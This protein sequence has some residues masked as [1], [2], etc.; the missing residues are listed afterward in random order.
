MAVLDLPNW[1][2]NGMKEAVNNFLWGGKGVK[3][4]TKTLI[5]DYNKGGLKLTDL[6]V[7]R[8]AIRVKT[9]KKYLYDKVEHGWKGYFFIFLFI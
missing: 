7:K 3:I 5:A 6:E 4:S 9:I 1:V 2:L 8:K